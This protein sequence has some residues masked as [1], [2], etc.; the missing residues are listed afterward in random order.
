M[1]HELAGKFGMALIGRAVN[2]RFHC[3]TGD[4]RLDAD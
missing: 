4:E 3:Y 1:G 2:R